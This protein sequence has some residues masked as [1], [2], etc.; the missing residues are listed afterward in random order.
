MAYVG[1]T[2][3]D[4]NGR[5]YD[6]E[7]D[8]SADDQVLLSNL[9]DKL[10]LP[11]KTDDGKNIEYRLTLVG[12]VRLRRGAVIKVERVGSQLIRKLTPR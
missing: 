8:E 1:V 4:P 2:I 9:I 7:S 6:A 10:D 5:E 12:A 11:R 3:I